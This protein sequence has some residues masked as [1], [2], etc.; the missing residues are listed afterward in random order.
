MVTT[1]FGHIRLLCG[2]PGHGIAIN[3]SIRIEIPFDEENDLDRIIEGRVT[4][5]AENVVYIS[6]AELYGPTED[7]PD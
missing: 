3:D 7:D 4:E 1:T 5:V 2:I 6:G